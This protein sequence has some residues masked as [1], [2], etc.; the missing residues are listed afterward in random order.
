MELLTMENILENAKVY[1]PADVPGLMEAIYAQNLYLM[2]DGTG[3]FML[4]AG[5]QRV[6]HAKGN[7]DFFG[8]NISLDDKTP[9]HLFEIA[10]NGKIGFFA[11]HYGSITQYAR[12]YP[13]VVY[14]IKMNGKTN[15]VGI[16][17]KDPVSR[18]IVEFDKVLS[19]KENRPELKIPAVG[20]TIYL[21][22][23]Y[24]AEMLT[25]AGNLV[26]D[27]HDNG[28]L[29]VLW[30]YPRGKAIKGEEEKSIHTIAGAAGVAHSLGADV[31]KLPFVE[32]IDIKLYDEVINAAGK[33][34][35]V[36]AGGS[37]TD[38]EL[39]LKRLYK[40]IEIGASGNATGRNIH[41]L[42]YEKA[43]RMCDSISSLTLYNKELKDALSVYQGRKT[44]DQIL[45]A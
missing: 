3:R 19:L 44:L 23:E 5:D 30:I 29:S 13:D 18:Q 14:L 32:N 31:V 8:E 12:E 17:Q 9:R 39:F 28:M 10:S 33:T 34:K 25:E 38:P 27:A 45:R 41:Q 15:F 6:E 35:V 43:V 24:E 40:Q 1:I 21:G 20:Y 4:F 16:D 42:D 11:A 36:F 7:T 37:S 2:T 26:A 22:S